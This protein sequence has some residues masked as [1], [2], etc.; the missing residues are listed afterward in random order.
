VIKLSSDRAKPCF[1]TISDDVEEIAVEKPLFAFLDAIIIHTQVR[2]M[3]ELNKCFTQGLSHINV[4]SF[5]HHDWQ[6]IDEEHDVRNDRL[7]ADTG[8]LYLELVDSNEVIA[9]RMDKINQ[10][11]RGI[12]LPGE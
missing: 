1:I 2:I 6:A 4:F 11:H 3:V 9:L 5:H 12:I 8:G 7:L 10:P